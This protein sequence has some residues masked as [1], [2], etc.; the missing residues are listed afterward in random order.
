MPDATPRNSAYALHSVLNELVQQGAETYD[1]AWKRT[2]GAAPGSAEFARRHGEVVNLVV[3]IGQ[4]GASL[5]DGDYLKETVESFLARWYDAVVQRGAWNTTSN[6]VNGAVHPDTLRMLLMVARDF[7]HT[8]QDDALRLNDAKINALLEAARNIRELI[9]DGELPKD[10]AHQMLDHVNHLEW[11][12]SKVDLFGD[13]PIVREAQSIT[14]VGIGALDR[15]AR[16]SKKTATTFVAAIGIIVAV[17]GGAT[18][19]AEN[20][21]N[22]LESAQGV[23]ETA[24]EWRDIIDGR[25]KAIEAPRKAIEAPQDADGDSDDGNVVYIEG[26]LESEDESEQAG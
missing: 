9:A 11:L 16:I 4:R 17:T 1:Q 5:P 3:T 7:D 14:G 24:Q 10:L 6:A 2:L 19:A 18:E 20:A 13:H 23:Y 21:N 15:V 22:F 25:Q 8:F 26:E 12:I